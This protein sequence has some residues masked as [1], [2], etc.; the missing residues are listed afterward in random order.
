M[1][2]ITKENSCVTRALPKKSDDSLGTTKVVCKPKSLHK[3]E[4]QSKVSE[5]E[6]LVALSHHDKV[7]KLIEN[8]L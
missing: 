2:E 5:D 7:H 6:I 3:L 4:S 1:V 8:H